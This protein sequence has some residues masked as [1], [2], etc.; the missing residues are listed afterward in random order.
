M[1]NSEN[2]YIQIIRF[3]NYNNDKYGKFKQSIRRKNKS[4]K[5]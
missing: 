4:V 1:R 2:Y 5:Y 3:N